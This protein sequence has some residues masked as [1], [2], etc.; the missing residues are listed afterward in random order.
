MSI[1][2]SIDILRMYDIERYL[3]EAVDRGI[4]AKK[5]LQDRAWLTD[6]DAWLGRE[7]TNTTRSVCNLFVRLLKLMKY[8]TPETFWLQL[9]PVWE[10]YCFSG[11]LKGQAVIQVP[12]DYFKY[13]S[14]SDFDKKKMILEAIMD[15]ARW[16]APRAGWDI[17]PFE[18]VRRQIIALNYKNEYMFTK[19]VDP[20]RRYRASIRCIHEMHSM[21][22]YLDLYRKGKKEILVVEKQIANTSPDEWDFYMFLGKLKWLCP[23]KVRLAYRGY[24]GHSHCFDKEEVSGLVF[25]F[26]HVIEKYESGAARDICEEDIDMRYLCGPQDDGDRQS[27][28]SQQEQTMTMIT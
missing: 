2:Q 25:D 1:F 10:R 16:I 21:N 8:R 26:S 20:S 27:G 13:R 19:G 22:I 4:I 14:L 11:D 6:F 17:Q 9:A 5:V 3:N 15:G 18:D 7:F 24:R 12:F 23:E 28:K